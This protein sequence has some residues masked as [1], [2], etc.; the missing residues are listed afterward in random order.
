MKLSRP[1]ADIFIPDGVQ[2]EAALKRTTHLCVG[3]HQDD[4]EFM[5]YNGIC[6]CFNVP[7]KWFTGVVVTDG[8]G[9]P[10]SGL[11]ADCTDEQ[12]RKLRQNEQK[13]AAAIGRYSC[14]IQMN[15]TSAS[16]KDPANTDVVNDLRTVFAAARPKTVYL[17]NPSDKHPTHVSA[18]LRSIAALRSLPREQRPQKVLGCEVW[19]SLDWMLDSDKQALPVDKRPNLAA[20]LSGVYDSQISG[21]KRYD[22]AVW[23]RYLSNATF[24]ESHATDKIE[25]MCFAVDLSPLIENEKLSVED[26]I[27]KFIDRFRKDVS[28]TIRKYNGQS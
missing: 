27:L 3:S 20:A 23:G 7:D 2:Q 28:D 5:A 22:T 25:G 17:H 6:E 24:F 4:V 12:M 18:S 21:G 19:R 15:H 14:V 8:A 26:F 1:D 13:T 9:S 11:Y 10:R 16:V